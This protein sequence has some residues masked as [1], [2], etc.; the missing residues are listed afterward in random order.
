MPTFT[1][2]YY[3][4]EVLSNRLYIKGTGAPAPFEPIG[5]D[6]GIFA[7]DNP[8]YTSEL[9]EAAKRG[10][11]GVVEI[12]QEEYEAL[13]KKSSERPSLKSLVRDRQS[14]SGLNLPLPLNLAGLAAATNPPPLHGQILD[15]P[16]A[17]PIK[18]PTE[19]VR[20]KT[21]KGFMKKADE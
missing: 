7:T 16:K 14:L 9:D 6:D 19:F 13:K 5:G 12:T 10:V 4:K 15:T 3:K 20:P 18:I 2:R 8:V 11:G 1:T 21:S 17:E